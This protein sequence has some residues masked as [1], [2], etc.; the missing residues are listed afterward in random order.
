MA[1]SSEI[2]EIEKKIFSTFSE[3]A[4]SM[5]FS[6]I[7]GSI[8]GALVVGGGT[9]SLQNIAKK[10]G[11]SVSMVSLSMDL[12][13]VLDTVKRVKKPRDRKLYIELKEDLLDSLKK[14]LIMRVKKGV[15][16][17]LTEFESSRGKL[18]KLNGENKKDVLNAILTLEN[19][20][21]R[22]DKYVSLLSDI[23]LP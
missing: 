4:K 13:E 2:H 3:L 18:E 14:I 10:T 16:G 1:D 19:E 8:I 22:L 23:K 11:Y 7:H 5:G 21:K 15:S 12:L 17:M 20:I 9:L 6:P